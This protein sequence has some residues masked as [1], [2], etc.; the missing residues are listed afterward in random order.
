MFY[1]QIILVF[2]KLWREIWLIGLFKFSIIKMV[3]ASFHIL[4]QNKNNFNEEL[5]YN[6]ILKIVGAIY[7]YN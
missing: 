5:G 1:Y 4:K 6:N 3:Y 7:K 2:M